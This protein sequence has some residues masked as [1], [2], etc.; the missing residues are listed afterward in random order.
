MSA[1]AEIFFLE[2]AVDFAGP[3]DGVE[4]RFLSFFA[5]KFFPGAFTAG[6][7]T[8]DKKP[9]WTDLLKRCHD[10]LQMPGA[11]EYNKKYGQLFWR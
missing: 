11:V 1:T 7:V 5:A 3:V 6:T 2:T 9:G 10:P 8:C 4:D